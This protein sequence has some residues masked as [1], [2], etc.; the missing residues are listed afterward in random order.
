MDQ[1]GGNISL[2][3]RVWSN[4]RWGEVVGFVEG[5]LVVQFESGNRSD[6]SLGSK[7]EEAIYQQLFA[8]TAG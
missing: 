1:P 8:M 3:E 2:G 4:N 5:A 6:P 7:V